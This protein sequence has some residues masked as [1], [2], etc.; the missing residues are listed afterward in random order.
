MKRLSLSSACILPALC[1]KIVSSQR[2][3]GL[4]IRRVI[5]GIA[6]EL[7]PASAGLFLCYALRLLT[8]E[9]FRQDIE[10]GWPMK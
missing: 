1:G 2:L 8:D 5:H 6:P 7:S 10:D 4:D 9:E 3:N